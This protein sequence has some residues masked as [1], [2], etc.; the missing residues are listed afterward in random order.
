MLREILFGVA[1]VGCAGLASAGTTT[2]D[3]GIEGWGVYFFNEGPLGD[4][5]RAEDGNPGAHL[6]VINT[7]TFGL[8]LRNDSNA[9]VLG[10]YTSKFAGGVNLSVDIKAESIQFFGDE[11]GRDVA[12]EL[13]DFNPEGSDYPWTSVWYNLGTIQATPAESDWQTLSVTI[14]DPSS[15]SLPAGWGGYGAEDPVTFEPI[16]PADRTFASVLAS[17]DEVR[18]TTFVPGFFFGFTNFDVRYDNVTVA[19]VPEPATLSVLAGT[20]ALLMRR[21]SR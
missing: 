14:A 17:V 7:D 21:R 13:V 1:V 3:N 18:F 19:A 4:F 5:E 11:V 6:Q 9:E 2:F 10:D 8:N 16:L 12:V 15:T 20:G